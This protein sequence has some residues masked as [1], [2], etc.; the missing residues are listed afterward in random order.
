M[1]AGSVVATDVAGCCTI[2]VVFYTMSCA[3]WVAILY[4]RVALHEL[5]YCT[6]YEPGGGS[7]RDGDS[8]F[9]I[10]SILPTLPLLLV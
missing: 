8:G 10:L 5:L 9:F 3:A 4:S 2:A 7:T 6:Q 1:P